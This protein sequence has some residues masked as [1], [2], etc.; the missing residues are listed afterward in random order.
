MKSRILLCGM[1]ILLT[2]PS[3]ARSGERLAMHVSPAVAFAPADLIVRTMIE[4]SEANRA[5]EIVAESEDFYRSSEIPLDGQRAP[6]TAQ[7]A[8]R[9]L[10]GGVYTVRAVLKGAKEEQLAETRQEINVVSSALDR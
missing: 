8:F 10:P 3:G 7:L 4:S 5:I 6:R 9:G 1:L 2:M